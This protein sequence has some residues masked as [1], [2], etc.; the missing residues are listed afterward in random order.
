MSRLP[1]LPPV[2][3]RDRLWQVYG[4][5]AFYVSLAVITAIILGV[6]P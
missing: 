2:L 6:M 4:P 3:A 1:P 5:I